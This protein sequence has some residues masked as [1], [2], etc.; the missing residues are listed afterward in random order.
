MDKA[1]SP[2]QQAKNE[3]RLRALYGAQLAKGNLLHGQLEVRH[4][5]P[6]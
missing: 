2:N 1:K 6:Q 3:L 5:Q 4:L